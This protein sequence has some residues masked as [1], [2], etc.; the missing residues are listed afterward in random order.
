MKIVECVPNFS[1]GRDKNIIQAIADEI[2]QTPQVKLLDIYSGESTNRTVITY[3]GTP[4]GVKEAAFKSIKKAAELIDMCNHQGVHPR[5]GATDVCPFVPVADVTMEQCSEIART[6]GKRVG[7]ELGIPVYLYEKSATR[8]D[9]QSLANIRSGQYEKLAEKIHD[10][11]WRPDF[12][13]TKFNAKSGATVMGARDFLIAFNVNL[14]TKQK[15]IAQHIAAT[16]RE[17]GQVKR[18][19]SGAIVHDKSGVRLRTAGLLKAVRAIGWYI[20]EFGHTQVSMNLTNF[21]VSPLH[22]VYDT[23][24]SEAMKMG[25]QVTGS[26]LVG[27]IPREAL[28]MAGSYYLKKQRKD[29]NKTEKEIIDTAIQ[30]LGLKKFGEFDPSKKIIEYRIK[31]LENSIGNY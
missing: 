9:C 10:L 21:R 14:A 4:N 19:S 6:V 26:E 20:E 1:E 31:E 16:I 24:R 22:I 17:S 27:L 30:S 15:K 13:E 25:T 23:I 12:G 29:T 28:M 18:D 7:E 8:E 5:L 3:I 11:K 2:Q